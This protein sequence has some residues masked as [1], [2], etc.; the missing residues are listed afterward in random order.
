M[1]IG[2]K[3]TDMLP[4]DDVATECPIAIKV[5]VEGYESAVLSGAQR[6]LANPMLR[7]VTLELCGSNEHYGA[8][9]QD[10]IDTMSGFGFE[11][12]SYDPFTRTLS[13]GHDEREMN[14]LFVRDVT[15]VTDRLRSA[16]SYKAHG[17]VL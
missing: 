4:L 12:Y 14:S 8:S 10:I 16:P 17:H 6:T 1:E 9:Q 3:T 13:R 2:P 11:R 7:A 15:F 5:D